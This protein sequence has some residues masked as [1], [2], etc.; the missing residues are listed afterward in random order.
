MP[1]FSGPSADSIASTTCLSLAFSARS[2][3]LPSS[4]SLSE[5]NTTK[6]FRSA[7][8]FFSA[9]VSTAAISFW[10]VASSAL[11]AKM[12][13]TGSSP[14]LQYRQ[15]FLPADSPLMFSGWNGPGTF[16]PVCGPDFRSAAKAT[17]P[18]ATQTTAAR[19]LRIIGFASGMLRTTHGTGLT[20]YRVDVTARRR[21]RPDRDTGQDGWGLQSVEATPPGAG[22]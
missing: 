15:A 21:I 2:L 4:L 3:S 9:A 17:V 22:R 10:R 13:T 20:R 11:R 18:R 12:A 7:L 16:S 5:Q 14:A 1:Y 6:P 19:R 8:E